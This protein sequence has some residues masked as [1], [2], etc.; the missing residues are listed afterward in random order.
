VITPDGAENVVYTF[1]GGA[2]GNHPNAGV[3][4]DA[5]GNLYGT[6][7][8]G[9][10]ERD[11]CR[12]TTGCGVVFEVSLNGTEKALYSFEGKG[13]GGGPSGNLLLDNEGNLYATTFW[14][15]TRWPGVV[16][17]VD[18]E[19]TETVLHTFRAYK[20]DG[21]H[22][23][24]NL[25]MD[26]Q[27]NLYGTTQSGGVSG[28]YGPP[29]HSNPCYYGGCGTV[30]EISAAGEEKI[31]YAFKGWGHGDGASPGSL[32]IDRQGNLYGLSGAGG[33]YGYGAIFE[34]TA[35]AAEKQ[36]YSFTGGEDGGYPTGLV[37]DGQG[38]L[39]GTA[40]T[41]GKYDDGTVFELTSSG[42]L[43]V[44]HNFAGGSDGQGPEGLLRDAQGNLYGTTTYGGNVNSTCFAGCGVVFKV[45][46]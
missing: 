24:G 41:G 37:L 11:G 35:S 19:G 36:L 13:D 20:G 29:D 38:D 46:P 10:Y 8:Y 25:V 31:L 33:I 15:S 39:Y 14:A 26:A 4:Q 7:S 17:K 23:G 30:F 40:A 9:G 27:G 3:I 18:P 16:F 1:M 42:M 28:Y 32:V 22:P 5:E 34:I 2:D 21:K 6:T 43:E 45:T 44:L 12:R